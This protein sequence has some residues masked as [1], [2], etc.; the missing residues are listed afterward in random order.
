MLLKQLRYFVAVVDNG[1][2]TR[3]SERLYVT[4]SAI[5]QQLTKLESE[6][7]AELF[8]RY[9]NRLEL[10]DSGAYYY[11]EVK[12]VL[13]RLD[14]ANDKVADIP[15]SLRRR[16]SI[17]YRGDAVD[18]LVAPILQE[19]RLHHGDI[20]VNLMRSRR[21]SSTLASLNAGEADIVVVK[22][23]VGGAEET[24]V[25]HPLRCYTYLTC[26]LPEG[27]RLATRSVVTEE[28]LAGER[29]VL[30]GER[31]DGQK[32]AEPQRDMRYQPTHDRLKALYPDAFCQAHDF[33]AAVTLAKAGFGVTL[34]D[35]SQVLAGEGLAFVPYLPNR[36]FEY[37]VFYRKDN[38]NPAIA[39]FCEAAG[40]LYGRPTVFCPLGRIRPMDEFMEEHP[41]LARGEA[42]AD[43]ALVV[44][45]E[46]G[47]ADFEAGRVFESADDAFAEVERRVALRG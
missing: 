36:F 45:V 3:A 19:L 40:E 34:V 23:E 7:G 32:M 43:T 14:N 29:L 11:R 25:A 18:A 27:H 10:T 21:T 9:G 17:Y 6:I 41:E 12:D 5:S 15:T 26:V 42:A 30:L 44:A 4:Q 20:E 16:L 37:A 39:R 8:V 28:D 33:I 1:G 46:R 2:V 47:R 13:S 31:G 22:R 35:S 24:L 38:F